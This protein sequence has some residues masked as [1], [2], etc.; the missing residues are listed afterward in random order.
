LLGLFGLVWMMVTKM[1]MM[2]MM[3]VI[4]M[5]WQHNDADDA[6]AY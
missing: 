3:M 6:S 1:M 4:K 2:M 5:I